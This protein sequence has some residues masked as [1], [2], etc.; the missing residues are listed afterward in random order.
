VDRFIPRRAAAPFRPATTQ[1]HCSALSGSA[2]VL[3]APE[4]HEVRRLSAISEKFLSTAWPALGNLKSLTSTVRAGPVE[5]IYG[6]L[7]HILEFSYVSGHWYRHRASIAAEA[8]VSMVFFHTS[9]ELLREVPHQE[10]NVSLPFPQGRNVD[11]KNIHAEKEIR[12]NLC[13]L[14]IA[15]KSRFVAAIMRASVRSVA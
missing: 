15:S 10:R 14:T 11:G 4:L 1:L 3:I 7:D 5:M 13:S 8:I 2:D 9:G 12:S 6:P